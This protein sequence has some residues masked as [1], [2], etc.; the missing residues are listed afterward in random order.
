MGVA[1][2]TGKI[3]EN[4]LMRGKQAMIIAAAGGPAEYFKPEGRYRATPNQIL[5]PITHGTLAACGFDVHEP[6]VAL[7]VLGES[8]DERAKALKNL[9][10][11]LN[12]L[13]KSP[14]WLVYYG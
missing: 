10:F 3:Y 2:D 13:V 4:G 6:Y 5:Y 8:A 12:N 14:Q 1:W 9:E 11:R 7:N